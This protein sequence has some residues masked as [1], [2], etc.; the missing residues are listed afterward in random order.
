MFLLNLVIGFT[1]VFLLLPGMLFA[2][3]YCV[4][5]LPKA[6]PKR[7]FP[8]KP[9]SKRRQNYHNMRVGIFKASGVFV[10]NLCFLSETSMK[11]S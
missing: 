9:I 1:G 7:D 4:I 11:W 5:V 8:S 10:I 6:S 3:N 2:T